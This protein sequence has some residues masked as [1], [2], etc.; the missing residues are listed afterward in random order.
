MPKK[1][2]SA[3]LIRLEPLKE[4]ILLQD[5]IERCTAARDKQKL[6]S[7]ELMITLNKAATS[8]ELD[9][10]GHE[11]K[12]RLLLDVGSWGQI[13]DWQRDIEKRALAMGFDITSKPQDKDAG[14]MTKDLIKDAKS[15]LKAIGWTAKEIDAPLTRLKKRVNRREDMLDNAFKAQA[16][17]RAAFSE[18]GL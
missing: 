5:E 17:T 11:D 18:Y 14:T 4:Q 15:D 9:P 12:K 2:S 16:F 1:L 8:D 13:L 3:D 6:R 10:M 7:F